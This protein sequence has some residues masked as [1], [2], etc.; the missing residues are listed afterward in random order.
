MNEVTD[1]EPQLQY[2]IVIPEIVRQLVTAKENSI[3]YPPLRREVLQNPTDA[4]VNWI[5]VHDGNGIVVYGEAHHHGEGTLMHE[6]EL[7]ESVAKKHDLKTV[8]LEEDE[9]QSENLRAY[10]KTGVM[11]ES[12]KDYLTRDSLRKD[13]IGHNYKLQL[14]SKCYELGVEVVFI[15]DK[16]KT[17]RDADW[18]TR[19]ENILGNKV[20]GVHILIAGRA[21]A[22]RMP[23]QT[24]KP[25]FVGQP[26]IPGP[27]KTS[28]AGLLEKRYAGN[29]L[30][31]NSLTTECVENSDSR[32]KLVDTGFLQG[33]ADL[34]VTEPVAI[35][36]QKSPYGDRLLENSNTLKAGE[37]D[38]TLMLP[39]RDLSKVHSLIKH[40]K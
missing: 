16:S 27:I 34:G 22:Y 26:E 39:G 15:D 7:V 4:I 36:T 17:D 20:E 32:V 29:V 14:V 35:E 9:S 24:V 11:P 1:L 40:K 2:A 5:D 30:T 25:H 6:V 37:Y 13:S 28:V 12:L 31:V 18:I 38:L 3:P 10:L 8:F 23:M 19:V 21:H 33:L